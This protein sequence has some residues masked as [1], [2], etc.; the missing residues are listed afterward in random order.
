MKVAIPTGKGHRGATKTALALAVIL[1]MGAMFIMAG[2]GDENGSDDNT[3]N[4]SADGGQSSDI[5]NIDTA[6]GINLAGDDEVITGYTWSDCVVE[7]TDRYGDESTAKS[8]CENLYTQ[9]NDADRAQLDTV[10]AQVETD[11][12]V[13]PGNTGGG[14][15]NPGG[16][17][18]TEDPNGG[19]S[20][21]IIVPP[22]P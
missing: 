9:H 12:G 20:T 19:W 22:A 5:N 16:G 18:G 17:G 11:L 15:G 1:L 3:Q 6:G 2:C 13:T 10:L 8:V 7:M 14:T 4:D 21:E